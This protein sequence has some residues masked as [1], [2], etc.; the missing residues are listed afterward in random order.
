MQ[1]RNCGQEIKFDNSIR[2]SSG[3][4]IPLNMDGDKHDC[5]NNP[6]KNKTIQL[7]PEDQAAF[8]KIEADAN[9]GNLTSTDIA[10]IKRTLIKIEEQT[11]AI[12]TFLQNK[13][14]WEKANE[15]SK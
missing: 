8:D 4:A 12:L 11:G 1:C 9:L 2:S 14:G 13:M 10:D 15:V 5:P 3:K 6:Y 7:K